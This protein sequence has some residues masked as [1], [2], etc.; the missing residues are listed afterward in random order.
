MASGAGQAMAMAAVGGAGQAVAMAAASGAGQDAVA[1]A[2]AGVD[3]ATQKKLRDVVARMRPTE[4]LRLYAD[5]PK[6]KT[7]LDKLSVNV[8]LGF[9]LAK[10]GDNIAAWYQHRDTNLFKVT[11]LRHRARGDRHGPGPAGG[12]R[13]GAVAC[14]GRR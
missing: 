7:R 10:N 5:P 2:V 4:T 8:F 3:A 1:V 6:D 11:S 13:P 12:E 14:G 9:K